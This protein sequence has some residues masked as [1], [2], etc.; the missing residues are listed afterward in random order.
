MSDLS[1]RPA[2]SAQ[3][4]PFQVLLNFLSA[5][6]ASRVIAIRSQVKP[7]PRLIAFLRSIQLS[8]SHDTSKK[9]EN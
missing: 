5:F 2:R 4:V 6:A 1:A 9:F 7:E 8:V 3:E